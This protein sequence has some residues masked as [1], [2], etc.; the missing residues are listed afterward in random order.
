[1]IRPARPADAPAIARVHVRA[2]QETYPGLLPPETIAERTEASR[3]AIWTRALSAPAAGRVI[4]AAEHAGAVA[5]FGQAGPQRTQ[6][7]RDMGH[8]GEVWAL[9]L[10]AAAQGAG[11]GRGLMAAMLAALARAGHRSAALWVLRDNPAAGFYARLGGVP[12][13]DG[14]DGPG[15]APEIAFAYDLSTPVRPA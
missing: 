1:M 3:L 12:V 14:T 15:G 10:V 4:L 6:A 8:T 13:L 11:L 5:G 2:W 9:Y 7:L